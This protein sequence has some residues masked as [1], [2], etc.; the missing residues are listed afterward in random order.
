[1]MITGVE[2]VFWVFYKKKDGREAA[3]CFFE[4]KEAEGK[5]KE[6]KA[7]GFTDIRIDQQLA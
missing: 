6:L 4:K 3:A 7:K 5:A 1:M 2:Y